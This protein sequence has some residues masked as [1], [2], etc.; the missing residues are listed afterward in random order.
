[1]SHKRYIDA[2][3]AWF[4]RWRLHAP[5]GAVEDLARIF[6]RADWPRLNRERGRLIDKDIDGTI[7][8]AERTRLD[9][10]QAYADYHLEN[11]APR[12]QCGGILEDA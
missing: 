12:P 3:L 1:M 5:A 9:V 10:L 7:T 8:S 4:R 2:A 11:V 6:E